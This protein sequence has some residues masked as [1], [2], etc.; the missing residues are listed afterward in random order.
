MKPLPNALRQELARSQT[1]GSHPDADLLTAFGENTL[2][3]REREEVLAHLAQ[4]AACRA[5]VHLAAA[6]AYEPVT[7]PAAPSRSPRRLWVPFFVTAGFAAAAVLT[8]ILLHRPASPAPP[9]EIATNARPTAP[10]PQITTSTRTAEPALA[11]RA[12]HAHQAAPEK[13][14]DA[15]RRAPVQTEQDR[16]MDLIQPQQQY[17]QRALQQAPSQA[18]QAE[19]NA[20]RIDEPAAAPNPVE[21]AEAVPEAKSLGR[22]S[23][24]S[25][26]GTAPVVAGRMSAVPLRAHWRLSGSGEVERAV[27]DGPWQTV[28]ATPKIRVISVAGSDVWAGGDDLRLMDSTDNGSTWTPVTLPTKTAPTH[29]IVHIRAQSPAS[30]T[31]EADDGTVWSSAD[32]GA[33]WH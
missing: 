31:V 6:P 11:K 22:R 14:A 32:G 9:M 10:A 24:T 15:K 7:A 30:L 23:V 27:A 33:T 26:A 1:A 28:L 4:C 16:T 25:L 18:Q 2:L 3:A 21:Q 19:L 20:N 8:V 12:A 5:V 17:Q 13:L 29:A